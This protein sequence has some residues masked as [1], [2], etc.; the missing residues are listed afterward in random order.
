MTAK[1]TRFLFSTQQHLR[2]V[3]KNKGRINYLFQRRVLIH[4]R[5]LLCQQTKFVPE[6]IRF[7]SLLFLVASN[8]DLVTFS[9]R[10]DDSEGDEYYAAKASVQM[11]NDSTV[12]RLLDHLT[13]NHNKWIVPTDN[14]VVMLKDGFIVNNLSLASRGQSVSVSSADPQIMSPINIKD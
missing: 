11:A 7:C 14:R 9:A 4:Q 3:I 2:L 6:P 10:V 13:I 5:G 12:F 1:K 8:D